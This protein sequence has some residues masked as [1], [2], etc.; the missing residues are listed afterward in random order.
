MTYFECIL[1]SFICEQIVK[2]LLPG[3][4]PGNIPGAAAPGAKIRQL[5]MNVARLGRPEANR[6]LVLEEAYLCVSYSL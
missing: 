6:T 4:L 5:M 2:A 1:V 3:N